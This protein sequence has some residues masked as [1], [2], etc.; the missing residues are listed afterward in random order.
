MPVIPKHPWVELTELGDV[1]LVRFNQPRLID[2][3]QIKLIGD[4]LFAVADDPKRRKCV[5]NLAGIEVLSSAMVGKLIAMHKK[6]HATGGRLALCCVCPTLSRVFEIGG[7]KRVFT[8]TE[9]QAEAIL[10]IGDQA[11]DETT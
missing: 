5:V 10:A 8:I 3:A 2:D 6:L 4:V 1:T 11:T 7:L 9:D